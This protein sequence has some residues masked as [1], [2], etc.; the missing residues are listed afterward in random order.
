MRGAS[1]ERARDALTSTLR[2]TSVIG[3]LRLLTF[4]ETK[5]NTAT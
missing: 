3:L 4:G 5:R 2:S 1:T